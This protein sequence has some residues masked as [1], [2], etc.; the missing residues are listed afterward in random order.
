MSVRIVLKLLNRSVFF[1]KLFKSMCLSAQLQDQCLLQEP[2]LYKR[3]SLS[4]GILVWCFRLVHLAIFPYITINTSKPS[5]VKLLRKSVTLLLKVVRPYSQRKP[6]EVCLQVRLRSGGYLQ[7]SVS[8]NHCIYT[9][10][11]SILV[12]HSFKS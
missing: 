3:C 7:T 9:F 11:I 5:F 12:G 1:N 2:S 10:R 4:S 8:E 6:Q